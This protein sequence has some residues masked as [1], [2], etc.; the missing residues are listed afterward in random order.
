MDYIQLVDTGRSDNRAIA[1]GEVSRSLKGLARELDIPVLACSQLSRAVEQRPNHRPLLSDL[2]ESGC[3]TGETLISLADSG[4]RIPIRD[5][6]GKTNFAIWSLNQETWRI[7]RTVVSDAFPTGVK[8]IFRI[9]TQLGRSIRATGN[10]KFLTVD[11]WKRLDEL[12]DR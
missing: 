6:S 8:P 3:L 2:R 11:G 4:E 9:V 12:P 7:E 5:L 1:L 10:H